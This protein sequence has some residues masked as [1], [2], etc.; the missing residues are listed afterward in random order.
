MWEE[1]CKL[2]ILVRLIGE[3]R[4]REKFGLLKPKLAY[5][6]SGDI[7]SKSNRFG[8]DN[9]IR[10]PNMENSNQTETKREEQNMS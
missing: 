1:V 4:R 6:A 3:G 10:L 2:G 5:Q 7:I 8:G 9:F